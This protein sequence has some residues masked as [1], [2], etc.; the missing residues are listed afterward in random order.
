[1][2][3]VRRAAR[4]SRLER[5]RNEDVRQMMEMEESRPGMVVADISFIKKERLGKNSTLYKVKAWLLD[6]EPPILRKKMPVLLTFLFRL[7]LIDENDDEIVA[8]VC[9]EHGIDF[10][11]KISVSR[12]V[13]SW[14]KASCLGLTLQNA[15]WFESSWGKKFS[16]EISASVWDLC[17][18]SIVMH[19]G[20]YDRFNIK[21]EITWTKFYC[22]EIVRGY[23]C[24]VHSYLRDREVRRK[25]RE[26]LAQ[27]VLKNKDTRLEDRGSLLNLV[28]AP[29]HTAMGKE[30][31]VTHT[32]L[33][34]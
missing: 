15:R 19:L 27:I 28:I 26:T 34:K 11:V 2:E 10:V 13:A 3:G 32:V 6:V 29:V 23:G 9:G 17:P 33:C 4:V 8:T 25:V 7:Y 18:P 1:M 21:E 30:F 14:S 16:H 22:T 5:R 31:I 20:S 24:T 12:A